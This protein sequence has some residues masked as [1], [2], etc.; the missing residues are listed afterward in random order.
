M[1]VAGGHSVQCFA[2]N[3]CHET[4]RTAVILY[5]LERSAHDITSDVE[6]NRSCLTTNHHSETPLLHKS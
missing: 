5:G 6:N 4:T 2:I 1:L 3:G